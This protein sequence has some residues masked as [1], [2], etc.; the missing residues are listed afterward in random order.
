MSRRL[1]LVKPQTSLEEVRALMDEHKLRHLLVCD[2]A[3]LLVGLISDRDLTARNG[4]TAGHVM[5]TELLTVEPRALVQPAITLLINKQ[6]SCLPVVAEGYPCGVLTST[7]L[8]MALQCTMQML[9]RVA[10]ETQQHPGSTPP[11]VR[12]ISEQTA[13]ADTVRR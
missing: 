1:F 10:V 12:T 6:I 7:D 2:A 8:M 3:G 9:Q 4:K 13:L 11:V 5:T